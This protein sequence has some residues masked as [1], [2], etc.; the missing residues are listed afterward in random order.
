M[1]LKTQVILRG[2]C[3]K[4]CHKLTCYFCYGTRRRHG[5]LLWKLLLV[6]LKSDTLFIRSG[7]DLHV[8][9]AKPGAWRNAWTATRIPAVWALVWKTYRR[10]AK[11]LPVWARRLSCL[12]LTWSTFS[13][14]YTFLLAIL[15]GHFCCARRL[16]QRSLHLVTRMFIRGVIVYCLTVSNREFNHSTQVAQSTRH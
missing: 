6:V 10:Y 9:P 8:W 3:Q 4:T 7:I 14:Y 5:G 2:R 16:I 12:W 13:E 1:W 15:I 11:I